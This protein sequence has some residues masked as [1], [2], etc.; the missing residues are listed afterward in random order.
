MS[1]TRN[2]I[3]AI[4]AERLARN[5][6]F[7]TP[8]VSDLRQGGGAVLGDADKADQLLSSYVENDGASFGNILIAGIREW[9]VSN[10]A[11]GDVESMLS[12][13][14]TLNLTEVERIL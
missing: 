12:P 8:R 9:M 10:Q 11:T 1:M 3:V 2:E 7:K 4:L 5:E 14:D 13:D 6:G